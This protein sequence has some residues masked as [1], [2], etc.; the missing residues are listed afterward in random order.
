MTNIWGLKMKKKVMIIYSVILIVSLI[1]LGISYRLLQVVHFDYKDVLEEEYDLEIIKTYG[2]FD[3]NFDHFLSLEL[4]G[5]DFNMAIKFKN[6]PMDKRP[7]QGIMVNY[8]LTTNG[9]KIVYSYPYLMRFQKPKEFVFVIDEPQDQSVSDILD[10]LEGYSEYVSIFEDIENLKFDIH[11]GMST[12]IN[13]YEWDFQEFFKSYLSG[14]LFFE[15]SDQDVIFFSHDGEL[16]LLVKQNDAYMFVLPDR[17][18][19]DQFRNNL[20]SIS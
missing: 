2:S 12:K 6:A 17:M 16:Y 11:T 1:V 20:E 4:P 19:F 14:V 5:V 9:E 18:T 15:L 8:H 13:L 10:I 3:V 7:D